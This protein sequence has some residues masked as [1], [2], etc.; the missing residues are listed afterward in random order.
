[1]GTKRELFELLLAFKKQVTDLHTKTKLLEILR[2]LSS[3]VTAPPP[4]L[5]IF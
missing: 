2:H 5:V 3:E 4:L 1:M